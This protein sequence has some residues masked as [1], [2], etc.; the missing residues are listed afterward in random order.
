MMPTSSR[1]KYTPVN[2]PDGNENVDFQPVKREFFSSSCLWSSLFTG[3]LIGIYYI[4]SIGLTFYQRWLFQSFRFPLITV[5]IHMIVKYVLAM[6]LRKIISKK[7]GKPRIQLS[8]KEYVLSV[9]PTGIFSGIDIGFSNW[10]LELISVS[11]YTMTKSTT[12]VFILLFSLLF[13]LEKKSWNL[14]VIVVMI[15]IGLILFTYK[16]TQFNFLG[17]VLLLLASI[18]SGIRWTCIQLLLQKSKIGMKNPLDMMYY[19]QPW[20]IISVLPFA[21]W[22]EGG[23]AIRNCQLMGFSHASTFLRLSLKVLLGAFIA[24][25]MEFS[26]VT[27]VTYTSSLTLGIAGIFKEIFQLVLSVEYAGDQLSPLNVVG[28]CVCLGGITCHVV[29]KIRG[30]ALKPASTVKAVSQRHSDYDLDLEPDDMRD[31]LINGRL[32][33]EPISDDD[34]ARSETEILFDILNRRDR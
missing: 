30:E 32:E 7:Q 24:F 9:S 34:D 11:L 20:M 33:C 18:S 19:M 2:N 1:L 26:E 14:I 10:G 29:H 28:L 16:S 3:I 15:T 5:L 17:F 31:Q 27:V 21:M 12:I 25:F 23:D 6:I 4:P 22:I 13:K 8:W